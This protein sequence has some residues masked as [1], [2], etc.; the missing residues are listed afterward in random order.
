MPESLYSTPLLKLSM[1]VFAL[2]TLLLVGMLLDTFDLYVLGLL[3]FCLAYIFGVWRILQIRKRE[4]ATRG[5]EKAPADADSKS[6]L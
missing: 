4:D 6:E 1:V 5:G 2:V 3:G